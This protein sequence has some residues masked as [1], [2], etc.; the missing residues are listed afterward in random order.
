MSNA[1]S[2]LGRTLIEAR[3]EA[4]LAHL[5]PELAPADIVTAMRVQRDVLEAI[6]ASVAGWKVG[7]TPEGVPVAAPIYAGVTH[8][9]GATLR[10]GPS[11][12]SGI[13]VE[14]ALL[15]G[16]DLPSRPGKPYDRMEILDAGSAVLA[17][18]EIVASRFPESPKPPFLVVV[19]DNMGNG[20]YVRGREVGGF[21]GLDL[22]KLRSRLT[23]DGRKMHDAIGG[24]AK[25]DP[26]SPIVDYVNRPCDLLGGLK[27]GQIVTTGSLSGCPYV[28]GATHIAAE[29][30]GLGEIELRFEP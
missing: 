30:E 16:R 8:K 3:R 10:H 22:S 23:I 6:G 20:G 7:Y 9:S 28:E 26:L 2:E 1:P 5:D 21:R 15:L 11:R 24:H 4:R 13:E 27:A 14:I 19:A 17:G 25:G 18:V 12:K 29:V